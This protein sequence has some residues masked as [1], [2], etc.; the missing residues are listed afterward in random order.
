MFRLLVVEDQVDFYQDYLLRIFG[1]L[2]PMESISVVHVPTLD[3]A[4]V[5][6]QERWD[7]ILM[8]YS[9]GAKT[10]FLGDPVRDGVDL[11]AFR[12][13]IEEANDG[14]GGIPVAFILGTSSNEVG[15]RLMR[16]KGANATVLKIQVPE[17][18]NVIRRSLEEHG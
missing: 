17:M 16:G 15:N 14:C 10:K 4:L 13:A 1:K 18:A 9:L 12:R 6:L 3:A 11:I 2:L 5:A 8:D 7:F